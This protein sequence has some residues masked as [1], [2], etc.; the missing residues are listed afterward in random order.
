MDQVGQLDQLVLMRQMCQ[1]LREL[2]RFVQAGR[3]DELLP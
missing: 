1:Q 2:G 3:L